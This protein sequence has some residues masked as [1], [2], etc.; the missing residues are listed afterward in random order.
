MKTFESFNI[1]SALL[2]AIG[3]QNFS[4]PTAA[5]K[6]AIPVLMEWREPAV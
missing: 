1:A 6:R 4:V 2:K 5:Q 3:E